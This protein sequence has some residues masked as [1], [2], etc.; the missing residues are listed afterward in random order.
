MKTPLIQGRLVG[1]TSAYTGGLAITHVVLR[2][3]SGKNG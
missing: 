2:A 1:C 3:H